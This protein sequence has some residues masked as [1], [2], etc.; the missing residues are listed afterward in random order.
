MGVTELIDV[1]KTT[2]RGVHTS[3]ILEE[4]LILHFEFL[5][6]NFWKSFLRNSLRRL[7]YFAHL[8]FLVKQQPFKITASQLTNRLS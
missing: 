3:P 6:L 8:T 1:K 2:E 7:T 5:F 4:T